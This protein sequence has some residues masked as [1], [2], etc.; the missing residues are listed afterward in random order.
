M[1]FKKVTHNGQPVRGLWER[2]RIFY[3][4]LTV[5]K[6]KVA[7]KRLE[8]ETVPQAVSELHY[9]KHGVRLGEIVQHEKDTFADVAAR[10]QADSQHKRLGTVASEAS[11]ITRL[12]GGLGSMR[13][14]DI[15]HSDLKNYRTRRQSQGIANSTI[16]TEMS[17]ASKVFQYA[18]DN[19]IVSYN[20]VLDL[21]PLKVAKPERQLLS[22]EDIQK[23]CDTVKS[24]KFR[25]Y[26][27]FLQYTGAREQEA[28]RVRWI[29]VEFSRNRVHIGA[30][31]LSKNGKSRYVEMSEALRVHLQGMH[32]RSDGSETLF[33][34]DHFRA[35]L[36]LA[37]PRVGLEWVG[38]HDFRRHFVSQCVMSGIDFA[39]IANW[40]GHSDSGAL[41]ARKYTF[42][43][44]QHVVNQA[45][46]LQFS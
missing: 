31:G 5:K 20:T 44:S 46:K 4:Q 12:C 30:D 43:H 17:V 2:N 6:G 19:G 41:L 35:K 1:S 27:R 11:C 45:K 26:L 25:D 42:L 38:F 34:E 16:N 3:A 8:A 24:D 37:R 28:L 10:Y 32:S 7:R 15:T 21:K 18:E 13:F 23:L 33:A 29:D 9:I 39:T 40:V 14:A 36:E 22:N